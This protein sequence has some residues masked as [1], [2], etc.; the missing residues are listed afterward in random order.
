MEWRFSPAQTRL[1]PPTILKCMQ[2][3]VM[4][5]CL[6]QVVEG[7]DGPITRDALKQQWAKL[8]DGIHKE[9]LAGVHHVESC[10]GLLYAV[11]AKCVE[12]NV[13]SFG[14]HEGLHLSSLTTYVL[15][16]N[17]CIAV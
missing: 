15:Q 3:P 6:L 4:I 9:E 14:V 10:A 5:L 16:C 1:A 13:E 17:V 2:L 8:A 7:A 12:G 11:L